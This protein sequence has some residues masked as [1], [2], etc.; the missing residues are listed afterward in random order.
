MRTLTLLSSL[1]LILAC[2]GGKD[3][4]GGGIFSQGQ[5]WL[6]RVHIEGNTAQDEGGGLFIYSDTMAE[7]VDVDFIT[8]S[9]EDV[10]VFGQRSVSY[11]FGLGANFG[12]YGQGD[13]VTR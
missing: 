5:L 11:D 6:E 10:F 7:G 9:P 8:N 13:C 1:A 12:C 4:G 2:S 3:D